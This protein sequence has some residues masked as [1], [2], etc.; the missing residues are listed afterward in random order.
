MKKILLTTA[1]LI[2]LVLAC[3]AMSVTEQIIISK[4]IET[5]PV[6][7]VSERADVALMVSV[8]NHRMSR[9]DREFNQAKGVERL[10]LKTFK[11]VGSFLIKG[12][13][14]IAKA[15]NLGQDK[16]SHTG[17]N[18]AEALIMARSNLTAL[19]R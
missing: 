19:V 9:N 11:K 16:I 15:D 1:G 5:P 18:Y 13:C 2:G 3:N 8:P 14:R 6:S 4:T 10:A 12:F 7:L 17:R